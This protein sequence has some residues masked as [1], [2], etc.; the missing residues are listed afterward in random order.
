MAIGTAKIGL[1]DIPAELRLK[2]YRNCFVIGIANLHRQGH[3]HDS[4]SKC[5]KGCICYPDRTDIDTIGPGLKTI[6]ATAQL[7]RACKLFYHEG[8]PVL[9]G[10][11]TFYIYDGH[12]L[13]WFLIGGGQRTA[14]LIRSVMLRDAA[15]LT[16][17]KR[18][19]NLSL[20]PNLQKLYIFGAAGEWDRD[21]V[22]DCLP[23]RLWGSLELRAE[24][25]QIVVPKRK[26]PAVAFL[27]K[28]HAQYPSIQCGVFLSAELRTPIGLPSH[29]FALFHYKII[30]HGRRNNQRV[31]TTEYDPDFP[32]EEFAAT[33]FEGARPHSEKEMSFTSQK[34]IETPVVD[35]N[36]A[37]IRT[38][39]E[40][41][42][43]VV[44]DVAVNDE[45]MMVVNLGDECISTRHAH[46][47]AENSIRL[48]TTV[49]DE[50]TESKRGEIVQAP[51]QQGGVFDKVTG[52]FGWLKTR[53]G[54]V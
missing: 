42:S 43:S 1:A 26:M 4:R 51:E 47:E 44:L 24:P 37:V 52:C 46:S 32:I 48:E 6:R 14:A 7:L 28:L 49:E 8:L 40:A 45:L 9:Y 29:R 30:S 13:N 54:L 19:L 18:A 31:F 12:E 2:V 27:Q 33:F 10:E 39:D 36:K 21:A 50:D 20:L 3:V 5:Y 53:M 23:R 22:E 35:D 38:P 16:G 15:G 17:G 41:T 34:W 25:D 11:N